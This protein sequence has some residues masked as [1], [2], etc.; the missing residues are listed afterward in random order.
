MENN[1]NE[2]K[3]NA[4]V[5]AGEGK[6]AEEGRKKSLSGSLKDIWNK[7]AGGVSNTIEKAG[8]TFEAN[9]IREELRKLDARNNELY[10][11]IGEK[12]Y[13]SAKEDITRNDFGDII[14]EIEANYELQ[15]ELLLKEV[16]VNSQSDEKE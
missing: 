11:K 10:R 9:R 3:D 5:P 15:K 7:V 4:L 2:M 1:G 16:M 14:S 8:N 12:V 13:R 6:E